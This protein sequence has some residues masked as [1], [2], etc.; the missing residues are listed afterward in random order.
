MQVVQVG[1][2]ERPWQTVVTLDAV[3]EG[4]WVVDD[5]A[6]VQYLTEANGGRRVIAADELAWL[7]TYE[8]LRSSGGYHV[9]WQVYRRILPRVIGEYRRWLFGGAIGLIGLVFAGVRL[10]RHRGQA[11]STAARTA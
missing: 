6:H 7:P 8:E 2:V 11:S 5:Q 10:H 9:R 1:P 3:P 4:T